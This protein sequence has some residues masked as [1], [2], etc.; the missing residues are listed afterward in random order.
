MPEKWINIKISMETHDKLAELGNLK[1]T[2]DKVIQRLLKG[3][4][5]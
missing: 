4:K 2:Y 3:S 5:E 1:D